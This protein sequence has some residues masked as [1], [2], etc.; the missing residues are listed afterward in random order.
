GGL[1][2]DDL[3][4]DLPPVRQGELTELPGLRRLGAEDRGD[5]EEGHAAAEVQ[6]AHGFTSAG[7]RGQVPGPP[8]G[9]SGTSERPSWY[10]TGASRSRSSGKSEAASSAT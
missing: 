1:G 4:V 3:G 10:P 9:P 6:R 8:S 5:A 2:G 7:S